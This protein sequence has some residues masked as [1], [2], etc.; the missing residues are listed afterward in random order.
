M[1]MKEWGG[2]EGGEGEKEKKKKKKQ[3]LTV[4]L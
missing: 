1:Q 2:S 3:M 4:R